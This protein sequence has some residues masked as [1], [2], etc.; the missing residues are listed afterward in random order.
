MTKAAAS[1]PTSPVTWAGV[2]W[3]T[4]TVR[5]PYRQVLEVVQRHMGLEFTTLERGLWLYQRSAI[6]PTSK[7][8]VLWS[9]DREDVCVLLPGEACEMLGTQN[10][11]ALVVELGLTLTRLDVAWDT[12]LLTPVAARFAYDSG[13]AV[14]RV[15]S[16][17]WR[18]NHQGSTF[19]LGKRGDENARMVRFY[20]RRGRESGDGT[21]RVELELHGGRAVS[22]WDTL[23]TSPLEL[24]SSG[25]LGYLR[26]LV[27]FRDLT[28]DSNSGRC[29]PL[30]WWDDFTG[31]AAR[32]SL[33]LKPK[34]P[35]LDTAW[36]WLEESVSATLALVAD[37]REILG[38]SETPEN[39]V[40][41]M[42]EQGRSRYQASPRQRALKS[43]WTLPKVVT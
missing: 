32:L 7:A 37:S 11:L 9:P 25:C 15:R 40:R 39:F 22:L 3:L 38:A 14:T 13:Q 8:R 43:A 34:P 28:Q 17:D 5:T 26:D 30:P 41:R 21:T 12:T 16:W 6:E 27:D 24:W 31:G 20:D 2:H 35:T 36:G 23:Q 10:L 29:P 1:A 42:L 33:P 4:G 18:E 19:Y